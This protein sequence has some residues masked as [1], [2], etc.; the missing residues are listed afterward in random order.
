MLNKQ[1]NLTVNRCGDN[2]STV[3]QNMQYPSTKMKS[4]KNKEKS[5][6]KKTSKSSSYGL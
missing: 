2:D 5:D 6:A 1:H 3:R 4:T